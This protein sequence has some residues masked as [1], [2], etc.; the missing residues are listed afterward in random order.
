MYKVLSLRIIHK[1]RGE[2]RLSGCLVGD[3]GVW[4][5]SKLANKQEVRE[6][7]EYEDAASHNAIKNIFD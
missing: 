4:L 3:G 2:S 7:E 1:Y 5:C 6:S